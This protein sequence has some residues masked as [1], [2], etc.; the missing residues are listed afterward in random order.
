MVFIDDLRKAIKYNEALPPLLNS[1]IREPKKTRSPLVTWAITFFGEDRVREM[2]ID[3]IKDNLYN[4][5]KENQE[6]LQLLNS[7]EGRKYLHSQ[8]DSLLDFLTSSRFSSGFFCPRCKRPVQSK[9]AMCLQCATPLK[10][11]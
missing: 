4:T 5:I 2:V 10:W 3:A 1:C 7:T 11:K 6:S 9:Q 8:L